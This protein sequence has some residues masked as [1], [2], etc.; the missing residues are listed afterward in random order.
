[1]EKLNDYKIDVLGFWWVAGLPDTRYSGRLTHSDENGT[2][3]RLYSEERDSL[4]IN[5][6]NIDFIIGLAGNDCFTLYSCF[7]TG[8]N[9]SRINYRSFTCNKLFR[10]PF[11]FDSIKDLRFRRVSFQLSLAQDWMWGF[12]SVDVTHTNEKRISIRLVPKEIKAKLSN[13]LVAVIYAGYSYK[14]GYNNSFHVNR[15]IWFNL[16]TKSG[17]YVP[18]EELLNAAENFRQLISIIVKGECEFENISLLKKGSK[19]NRKEFEIYRMSGTERST[20]GSYL[21]DFEN[22]EDRLGRIIIKWFNLY[23]AIPETLNLFYT[24]YTTK[25]HYEHHYRDTFVAL[26]G[27]HQWQVVSKKTSLNHFSKNED[28]ILKLTDSFISLPTLKIILD[29]HPHWIN[30]AVDNRHFQTHLNK[31]RYA[32]KV[33]D[34]F[35]LMRLMRKIQAVLLCNIL[36]ELDFSDN[37]IENC[38]QRTVWHFKPEFT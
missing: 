7:Q 4:D 38:L 33:V 23:E 10:G 37:D 34:L 28:V 18:N 16:Y 21:I 12:H 22:Y 13:E 36:R 14:H 8:S 26:E 17:S 3:L 19:Y 25:R 9:F 32:N 31:S 11:A 20:R 15:N 27:F 29:N 35:E 2:L 24:V 6:K 1:M 30:S 5:E